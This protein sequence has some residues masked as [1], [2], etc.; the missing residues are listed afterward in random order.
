MHSCHNIG[1][2]GQ[3][4]SQNTVT[5]H[6]PQL[7]GQAFGLAKKTQKQAVGLWILSEIIVNQ[8]QAFANQANGTGSYAFN[9]WHLLLQQKNFQQR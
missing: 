4:G 9:G 5:V 2:A 6:Q 3:I 7:M 1:K 8:M